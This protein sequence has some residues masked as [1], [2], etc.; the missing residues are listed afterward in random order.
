M[1]AA[2]WLRH[3]ARLAQLV[4]LFGRALLERRD[5][6]SWQDHANDDDPKYADRLKELQAELERLQKDSDGL[7]DKMPLDDA[8]LYKEIDPTVKAALLKYGAVFEATLD[9]ARDWEARNP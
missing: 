6:P 4:P 8:G 7:P 5:D 9:A 3:G 1:T 2:A